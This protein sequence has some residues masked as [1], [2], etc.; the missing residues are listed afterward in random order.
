MS[1]GHGIEDKNRY[2]LDR[3]WLPVAPSQF[4]LES[5]QVFLSCSEGLQE[6]PCNQIELEAYRFN[7]SQLFYSNSD[8]RLY[9][10]VQLFNTPLQTL[11][12]AAATEAIMLASRR[13]VVLESSEDG[14]I[15]EIYRESVIDGNAQRE[16]QVEEVHLW[17]FEDQNDGD[18]LAALYDD[19]NT[20]WLCSRLKTAETLKPH[21]LAACDWVTRDR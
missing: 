9:R 2:I 16:G 5:L 10:I 11:A 6:L 21:Y 19:R 15:K 17:L 1:L 12:G 18:H 13:H 7:F 20:F 3:E 8:L 14:R 4:D